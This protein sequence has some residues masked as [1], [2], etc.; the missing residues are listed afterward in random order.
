M[1]E[2]GELRSSM[3]EGGEL[4]SPMSEGGELRSPMSEGGLPTILIIW[5]SNFL[6][7]SDYS[8]LFKKRVMRTKFDIYVLIQ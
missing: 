7:V 1:S 8:R 2:G 3:S 4:R 6:S 5:L